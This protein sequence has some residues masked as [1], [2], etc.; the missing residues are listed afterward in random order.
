MVV[1]EKERES[2]RQRWKDILEIVPTCRRIRKKSGGAKSFPVAV[3]VDR[4]G[5]SLLVFRAE[6]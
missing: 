2:E 1:E 3:A 6:E 5:P 4:A